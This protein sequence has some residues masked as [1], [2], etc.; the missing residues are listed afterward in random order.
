MQ[1]IDRYREHLARTGADRDAAVID[2]A[3]LALGAWRFFE[4]EGGGARAAASPVGLVGGGRDPDDA[5]HPLLAA[6]DAAT[7]AARIAWLESRVGAG[8]AGAAARGRGPGRAGPGTIVV[9]GAT[10]PRARIDPL[11]W[12]AATAPARDELPG[13]ARRLTAWL[14][15]DGDEPFRLV[16]TAPAAGPATIEARA[17]HTLVDP[18]DVAARVQAALAGDDDQALRWALITSATQLMTGA[19]PAIAALLSRPDPT[20][21]ADAAVAL[22]TL[23]A[24]STVDALAAACAQEHDAIARRTLLSALGNTGTPAAI[25]ALA[26]LRPRIADA[27]ARIDLV[28]ALARA[29]EST[30]ASARMALRAVAADDADAAVRTLAASYAT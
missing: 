1:P 4:L 9:A 16:I 23:R 24:P 13:G 15:A 27:A 22:A 10:P 29:A 7:L 28:H 5:W 12:R 6:A 25:E 26:A 2:S 17:A 18:G 19:A 8:R 11:L 3:D 21:R 30:P 14:Y 20:V